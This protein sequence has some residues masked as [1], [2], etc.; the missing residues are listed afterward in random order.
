MAR[1]KKAKTK[2]K[3]KVAAVAHDEHEEVNVALSADD[4]Y[5]DLVKNFVKDLRLLTVKRDIEKLRQYEAS[6]E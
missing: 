2:T 5:D 6:I 3:Q 1:S 4:E